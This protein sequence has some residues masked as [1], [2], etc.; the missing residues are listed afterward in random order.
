[1]KHGLSYFF[2]CLQ[3]HWGFFQCHGETFFHR[4]L[5]SDISINSRNPN[6]NFQC[7]HE[8]LYSV[9]KK[10]FKIYLQGIQ[11]SLDSNLFVISSF[12]FRN[13]IVAGGMREII[14]TF[15]R[16]VE[17]D[18]IQSSRSKTSSE[19]DY[20]SLKR[21]TFT[22]RNVKDLKIVKPVLRCFFFWQEKILKLL[23][24][25]IRRQLQKSILI[26]A[27][28]KPVCNCFQVIGGDIFGMGFLKL[29]VEVNECYRFVVSQIVWS[30]AGDLVNVLVAM[31]S[32]IKRDF[33]LWENI[34]SFWT[35]II[36]NKIAVLV[37]SCEIIHLEI[38][39]WR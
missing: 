32:P 35:L 27:Q 34:L 12:Q 1:M 15:C 29:C 24:I 18:I 36:R 20:R 6:E 10:W 7:A 14:C 9:D 3:V 11:D 4:S 38:Y 26:F 31:T 17:V 39:V 22:S 16:N 21:L 28:I 5:I 23:I 30:F 8:E 33:D 25:G 19:M 13:T 2:P 37:F